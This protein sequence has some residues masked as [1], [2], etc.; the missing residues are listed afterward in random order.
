MRGISWPGCAL[1]NLGRLPQARG[2]QPT[3]TP[4][5][6]CLPQYQLMLA[7]NSTKPTSTTIESV[8]PV[9]CSACA[10]AHS[11]SRFLS[12]AVRVGPQHVAELYTAS[13]QL[14]RNFG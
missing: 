1:G 14:R 10:H 12:C 8:R 4:Q 5:S 3:C 6:S 2:P 7:N 11:G 9:L 13:A